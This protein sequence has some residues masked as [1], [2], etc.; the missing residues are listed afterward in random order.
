MVFCRL[1]IALL[2]LLISLPCA[3]DVLMLV[4]GYLGSDRSWHERGIVDILQQRGHQYQG[5]YLYAADGIR[6]AET[7]GAGDRP[8]Y[9]VNLP[10]TAPVALQA[11]WLAA[12][13]ADVTRRH[14]HQPLTLAG[15]SAGGVVARFLVVTRPDLPVTRLI[16]I[17]S[18]HLGTGRA[19]QAL[20]ATSSSGMFGGLRRWAVRRHTGDRLYQV[21][22]GS[23]GVL[24][25]LT[26]PRPGNLL[27]WLNRQPHPDIEYI[28]IIRTGTVEM[29]GDRVV[30]PYSQDLRLVPAIGERAHSYRMAQ[31]HLLSAQ[32]G[33]LLANL[34]DGQTGNASSF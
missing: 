22:R 32:D 25:D 13:V 24:F 28:S 10:S 20:D 15:H 16:T 11:D 17:A 31:G 33:H 7:G 18:P 26:P 4:H 1:P 29:P 8:F 2:L 19:V 12:F 34:L 5:S 9:T 21:L 23:R 27:Y 6:F 14:P 30:P 3:A